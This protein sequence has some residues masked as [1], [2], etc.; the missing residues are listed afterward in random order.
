MTA[1]L[2]LLPATLPCVGCAH[3]ACCCAYGTDLTPEEAQGLASRHGDDK[4][5]WNGTDHR[6]VV[7][8][9]GRCVFQAADGRCSIHA[10]P[11][12]PEVCRGFPWR[13]GQ[14]DDPYPGDLSICPE[15]AAPAEG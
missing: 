10:D 6:T 3:D 5:F 12:Y 2:P 4:I 11:H 1:R 9:G 7:G 14:T 13:A 8:P 15:L